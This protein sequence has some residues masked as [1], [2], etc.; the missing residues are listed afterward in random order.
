MAFQTMSNIGQEFAMELDRQARRIVQGEEIVG[1]ELEQLNTALTSWMEEVRRLQEEAR[2]KNEAVHRAHHDRA[3]I[4]EQVSTQLHVDLGQT[5][6]EMRIRDEKLEAELIKTRNEFAAYTA[7]AQK[8]HQE[9]REEVVRINRQRKVDGEE[10]GKYMAQAK[11]RDQLLTK[12]IAEME[13]ELGKARIIP[14]EKAGTNIGESHMEERL[15]TLPS[16]GGGGNGRGP[17]RP[18]NVA[19]APNPGDD[20]PD[21]ESYYRAPNRPS[22]DP[23]RQAP[24]QDQAPNQTEAERISEILARTMSRGSRR[25]A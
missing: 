17:P 16:E 9:T 19:G 22:I 21:D 24:R 1:Q 6:K 14:T 18:P 20:D 11:E 2:A 8:E 15:Q 4:H 3:D 10:W 5:T 23:R 13:A 25:A 12:N 7:K